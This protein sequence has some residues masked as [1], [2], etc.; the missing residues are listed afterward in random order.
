MFGD[1]FFCSYIDK[2]AKYKFGNPG[3]EGGSLSHPPPGIPSF[4]MMQ[5]C[6]ARVRMHLCTCQA[7]LSF[8]ALRKFVID[9]PTKMIKKMYSLDEE[10]G[11][12]VFGRARKPRMLCYISDV[13]IRGIYLSLTLGTAKFKQLDKSCSLKKKIPIMF[14]LQR[15]QFD[16]QMYEK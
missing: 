3:W 2:I 5:R 10:K 4:S 13:G 1:R 12:L 14:Y 6:N 8:N 16:C 11:D 7:A 15:N 9:I